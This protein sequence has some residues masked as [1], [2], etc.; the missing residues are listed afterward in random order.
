MADN[1]ECTTFWFNADDATVRNDLP[2][3]SDLRAVQRAWVPQIPLVRVHDAITRL[4]IAGRQVTML[5][6]LPGLSAPDDWPSFLTT[7]E[8]A[9]VCVLLRRWIRQ[10]PAAVLGFGVN[11]P[12][13]TM[14]WQSWGVVLHGGA[15]KTNQFPYEAPAKSPSP[16]REPAPSDGTE[17]L[18]YA[19]SPDTAD[20]ST[21]EGETIFPSLEHDLIA[22]LCWSVFGIDPREESENAAKR[23]KEVDKLVYTLERQNLTGSELEKKAAEILRRRLESGR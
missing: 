9:A 20:V 22:R 14:A 3:G 7:V 6:L 13:F 16:R 8:T 5:V 21:P 4:C 19:S 23:Y 17:P 15:P 2:E 12:R 18:F 10:R 11:P 1:S